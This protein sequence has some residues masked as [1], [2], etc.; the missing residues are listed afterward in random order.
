MASAGHRPMS[1]ADEA[2]ARTGRS[3]GTALTVNAGQ[4]AFLSHCPAYRGLLAKRIPSRGRPGP[5]S[6][7]QPQALQQSLTSPSV[8]ARRG[9]RRLAAA[10]D[11]VALYFP[12]L[13]FLLGETLRSCPA[14]R[15]VAAGGKDWA[16]AHSLPRRTRAWPTSTWPPTSEPS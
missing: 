15:V 10:I 8:E 9:T 12:L 2:P 6:G 11:C 14:G 4:H 1:I 16:E 7:P 3:T 5:G 13:A